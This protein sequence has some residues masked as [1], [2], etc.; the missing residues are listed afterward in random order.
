MAELSHSNRAPLLTVTI[1]TFNRHEFL[2]STAQA[3]RGQER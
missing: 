3:L 2:R 1:P